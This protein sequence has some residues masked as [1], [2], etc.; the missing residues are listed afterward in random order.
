MPFFIGF[1]LLGFCVDDR[2]IQLGVIWLREALNTFL[3]GLAVL[4]DGRY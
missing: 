2:M 4:R 3:I 1:L